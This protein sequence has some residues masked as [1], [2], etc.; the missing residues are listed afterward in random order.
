MSRLFYSKYW[1]A[2]ERWVP[3][4]VLALYAVVV[5]L[6]GRLFGTPNPYLR[7]AEAC[8][9][10]QAALLLVTTA[11]LL[12]SKS[13]SSWYGARRRHNVDSISDLMARHVHLL[14]DEPALL[15]EAARHPS[16]FLEVWENSLGSLKGSARD[17]VRSL[18]LKSGLH[19]ALEVRVDERNPGRALRAISLLS[20]VEDAH[21]LEIIEKA[22]E[23]PSETV[24]ASA[25]I[26]LVSHGSPEQQG[27]VFDL[28]PSLPFWQR[29][30]LFHQV[31][32]GSQ[33]LESYLRR[34]FQSDD[35]LIVLAALE[36]VLSRQRLQQCG[37][38]SRLS[39][40]A[41]TEVR[42]KL[43]KAM[44]FLVS[45]DDPA[46]LIKAGLADDD[47]RVRAMA[48]RAAGALHL[49]SLAPVLAEELASSSHPVVIGHLA[50]ALAGLSDDA[51]RRLEAF[52]VSDNDMKR[53]ITAEVLEKHL[54]RASEMVK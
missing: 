27:R 24:R 5:I 54:L 35:S 51:L 6:V 23:H 33:A 40:W 36:F 30:V 34:A 3:L 48:A 14:E 25:R 8:V 37:P 21:S 13:L 22:L 38:L 10:V 28:L 4:V 50:H 19:S 43:F 29:V 44:P 39:Q 12:A 15:R 47:W 7:Y 18:L 26:A 52:S 20:E 42:I 1:P 41:E 31:R 45:E 53:A 2:V 17:R 11:G 32:D 16:E 46:A 49:T 9:A